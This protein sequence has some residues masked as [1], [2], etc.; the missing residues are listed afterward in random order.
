MLTL[1]AENA[2]L[3]KALIDLVG[4][5]TD[6]ELDGMKSFLL[7]TPVSDKDKFFMTNAID[8]IKASNKQKRIHDKADKMFTKKL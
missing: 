2:M 6:E 8:A 5:E 7:L 1:E 4:A 3:R